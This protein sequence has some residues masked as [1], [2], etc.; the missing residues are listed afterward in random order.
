MAA[1]D[2]L[3]RRD[4]LRSTRFESAPGVHDVELGP[5]QVL[6]AVD[7]FGFSA[8]N[9]T[10]AAFGETMR[11]WDFFPGPEGWGRLPVWGFAD[12]VRSNV[13]G[14]QKGERIFGYLPLSTHLVIQ[15]DSI[16]DAGFVDS[17]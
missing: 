17:D 10:Y 12:V 4:D 16:K 2:F 14:I 9:I 13:D 11:Y 1:V 3:I 6:L 5:G 7:K 15:P 8:N